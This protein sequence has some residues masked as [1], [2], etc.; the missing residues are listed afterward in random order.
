MIFK[1]YSEW[2]NIW[3]FYCNML[4][5]GYSLRCFKDSFF[6]NLLFI[7]FDICVSIIIRVINI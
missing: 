1:Y 4:N 3:Y 5:G 7:I 6:L 2:Y